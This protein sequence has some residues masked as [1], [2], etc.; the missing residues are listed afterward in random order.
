MSFLVNMNTSVSL[1]LEVLVR[2]MG[3]EWKSDFHMKASDSSSSMSFSCQSSVGTSCRNSMISWN[4]IR[5]SS[6]D[7]FV[8]NA[9]HT[10]KWNSEKPWGCSVYIKKKKKKKNAQRKEL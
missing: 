10:Y 4:S 7:H 5:C 2:C 9:A 3:D 1:Y 6:A 8:R